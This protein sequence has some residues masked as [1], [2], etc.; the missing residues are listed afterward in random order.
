MAE[1]VRVETEQIETVF[2][3]NDTLVYLSID[4]RSISPSH[5]TG[6]RPNGLH[7]GPYIVVNASSVSRTVP[8]WPMLSRHARTASFWSNNRESSRRAWLEQD[9]DFESS[10][11]NSAIAVE[12]DI[13]LALSCAR[14]TQ[15]DAQTPCLIGYRD[16]G[17]S[18]WNV[19]WSVKNRT[20]SDEGQLEDSISTAWLSSW[21]TRT[22]TRQESN[23]QGCIS[24]SHGSKSRLEQSRCCAIVISA[25]P[26]CSHR[27]RWSKTT[28]PKFYSSSAESHRSFREPHPA[29]RT[30][31]IEDETHFARKWRCQ[32]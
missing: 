13:V 9:R 4:S 28:P 17:A 18:D 15:T 27:Y 2:S 32:C 29:V 6:K 19:C 7:K 5:G 1:R 21:D 11:L 10:Q 24:P 25:A 31:T 16:R 20:I 14:D 30:T 12:T 8:S 22:S 23:D 3:S 26:T